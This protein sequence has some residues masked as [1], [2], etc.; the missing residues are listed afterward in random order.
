MLGHH[1]SALQGSDVVYSRH[2]QTRAL[3]K[4]SMLLRTVRIGL[5]IEDDQMQEFGI[6]QTP[7]A[8]TPPAPRTPGLVALCAPPMVAPDA[9]RIVQPDA[10]ALDSAIEAAQDLEDLQSVKEESLTLENIESQAENITLF[11]LGVVQQGLVEIESSS[12]S[13]SDSS[14]YESSEE[15]ERPAATFSHPRY[16]EDVPADRDFYRHCKSGILH[17]CEVGKRVAMCK[18]SINANY[19]IMSR[20]VQVRYAKCIRCFPRNNNRLRSLG[21]VVGA[22]DSAVKR[23]GR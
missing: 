13:S 17:S 5:D 15:M 3:R 6:M 12:G 22:L 8:A 11:P 18:V 14:S 20:A 16:S 23:R 10:V 21:D 9:A 2:L 19:K 7:A 4:L 1:S